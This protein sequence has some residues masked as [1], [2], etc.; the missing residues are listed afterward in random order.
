MSSDRRSDT[1]LP[2]LTVLSDAVA[3][4]AAFLLSYWLRF[5]SPVFDALGF[6]FEAAPPLRQYLTGSLIVILLWIA[7]FHSRKMYSTRRDIQLADELASVVGVISFGML[8]VLSVAFFYREAS[9]SR[10]VAVLLWGS[11]IVL[12]FSGRALLHLYERSL[13]R[14][15]KALQ[16]AIVLGH[17]QAAEQVYTRLHRHTSFGYDILGYCADTRAQEPA[18]LARA[19][20]MGSLD[21]A[22]GVIAR[23][24]IPVAFIALRQEDHPRLFSLISACEGVNIE[25]MLV[26][27]LLEILTGNVKLREIEG[28]PFLKIKSIP[29]TVWGRIVKRS[30]DITVAGGLLVLLSPLFLLIALAI[31]IGSRGPVLFRQIRIGLD[32]REFAMLKFRSMYAGADV[33]DREAGLGLSNDPRRTRVGAVLRRLSLD[34]LPQ[35]INVL[36]GDMSLVGPRPERSHFVHE[37][38]TQV[39]KY[40]DRH[41]VKTGMTGW[42]Q[43]NGLRGN[44]SLA[45][46]LNYDLYYIE[47][48]SLGLDIKILLRTLHAAVSRQEGRA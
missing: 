39:P 21:E 24:R 40:L 1:L 46:R 18:A 31:R 43:V 7:L 48:W 20:Y 23:E 14:K 6:V 26:P 38:R 15:G 10:V 35:L 41:R 34:E 3:I 2:L 36:R 30:F 29:M 5:R 44:T 33:H 27:D 19:P 22:P 17:E 47:N 12:V 9:F 28:I 13:Y 4:E 37:F 45:E 8:I 11:T 32:G 42:A 16:R 25:F